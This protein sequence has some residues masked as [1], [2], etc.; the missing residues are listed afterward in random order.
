LEEETKDYGE[1]NVQLC[2]DYGG[3]DEI[4]RAVNGALK[5]KVR[6][7][8]EETFRKFLDTPEIP[9]PDLVIRTSG[10]KRTSG[11]MPYQAAYA[12]LAFSDKFFPDFRPEDLREIVKGF[13]KRIR[14]LAEKYDDAKPMHKWMADLFI[15][16]KS[17]SVKDTP[18]KRKKIHNKCMREMKWLIEK[19]SS[20]NH[21]TKVITTIK[22]GLNFW[23]TRIL[24]PQIEPTNNDG[25]RSLREIV[26]MKKIIGTLRNQNGADVMAKIMTLISTWR[27]NGQ[28]PFYSLRAI[29]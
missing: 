8:D 4:V 26:V 12:E 10:E 3:R 16:V 29:I 1:F 21:L 5:K 6:K 27:L 28:S 25:E 17:V 20:Y 7:V 19:F 22:N 23:F 2:L 9:D 11:M 13:G 24:H 18:V 15:V 14:E